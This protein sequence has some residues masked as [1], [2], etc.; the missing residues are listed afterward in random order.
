MA[1]MTARVS[2]EA[3]RGSERPSP[4]APEAEVVG[5]LVVIRQRIGISRPIQ[6]APGRAAL[7]RSQS[8]VVEN[9]SAQFRG[10]VRVAV[11]KHASTTLWGRGLQTPVSS[12]T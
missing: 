8:A 6:D 1:V 10:D 9:L 2:N 11:Y 7:C 12:I 4:G 3:G 5:L